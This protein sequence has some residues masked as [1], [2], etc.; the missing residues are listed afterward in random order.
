VG[1]ALIRN[2][3][4]IA[5][6]ALPRLTVLDVDR[7][8]GELAAISGSGAARR[9]RALLGELFAAATEP[10]QAFLRRLLLGELRQ[11]ALEG[12]MV[13][14]IAQAANVPARRVRRG[15]MLSGDLPRVAALALSAG[16][17]GLAV[18]RLQLMEPLK[19][20]LAQPAQ[21][22]DAAMGQ[23]GAAALEYKLDGAR[24]QVHKQGGAVRV[25]TRRL[26]EVT[27]SVPEI[28]AAIEALPADELILDGEA[29]ALRPD[30][31]PHPFQVTMRRFGRKLDV[32]AL[33]G[34]LPLSGFY[35]DCLFRDGEELLDAPVR[36]RSQALET[37]VPAG[38]LVPRLITDAPE[39]AR[40]FLEA[41]LRAGHEGL[42]VKALEAPYEAGSRGSAWLKVKSAHTLDL[43]VLAA[44]WGSGRRSGW[45]SNLHLGARDPETG[46]YVMLGKTFKGLTDRMLS[47]QTARL[48]SLAI[49]QAGNVVHVRPELVVE[50]AFNDLQASPHY[51]GGLALRFARVKRYR[52]DKRATD[53]DTLE[54]VRT[55]YARQ[56][57]EAG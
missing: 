3:T 24:I 9:R 14:A 27:G 37:I 56:G 12:V 31:R 23:L 19:P 5:P 28:V 34:A 17:A 16:E 18:F 15:L 39:T 21:D 25:F 46:G 20:M 40:Q 29:L 4:E 48:Q 1:P 33:R 54:T 47:W 42:M 44:E 53:A 35:F 30:G 7:A 22:L 49:G 55:L 8:L 52:E 45:L 36:T 41:A 10:E 11:G 57:A 38:A 26:N 13:E 2:A 6:A 50:I 43:V 51:P 32:A